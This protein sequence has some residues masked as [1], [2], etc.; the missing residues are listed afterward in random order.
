MNEV[1]Y[2]K[3]LDQAR[4]NQTLVPIRS[5]KETAMTAKFIR[6]MA[7]EKEA[8]TQ[9]VQPDPA[10]REI[11]QEE[12]GNV[13]DGN[14]RDL[15]SFGFAIHHAGM[16]RED[17]TLVEE[18]FTD[19]SV[20]VLVCTTTLTW[21]VNLSAHTVII[22]GTQIYNPEKGRWV[23]LSSQDILQMLGCAGWPQYDTYGEAIII[24][25]HSEL[26]YYLSLMN[27]QLPIESQ[28]VSKLAD[29]LNAEI[30]LGTVRNRDEAVLARVHVSVSH[31]VLLV[32]FPPSDM[33]TRY[34]RMLKSPGLYCVGI[35]YQEDDDGLVQKCTDIVHST[36][37]LLEKCQLIKYEHSCSQFQSMELGCI[38]S[39][40]YVSHNSMATYN[41]HLQPTMST[42]E[43]FRVFALSSE[44]KLLPVR[45]EEKLELAKLLEHVPIPVKESVNEP[46]AMINVLLQ[47]YISQLKLEGFALVADMV[48]VQQS[49]GCILR[50]IFIFDICLK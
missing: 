13:K 42:L 18:L 15:L 47:A 33:L 40:Y 26:Q 3:L 43:L 5:H 41:Q 2:E 32:H 45:Q 24:T 30:V 50:A 37:A 8:I 27:Q 35:D 25:N 11:L 48:F 20:Q 12:V 16:S 39:H 22:K 38:A 21:G 9:F 19:G 28:F 31:F 7:I 10:T 29:N 23:K 17:R 4:K 1:C 14:L 44:F 6:D 34:V 46:T 36:A 49:A